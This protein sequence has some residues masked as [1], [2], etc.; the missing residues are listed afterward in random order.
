MTTHLKIR[1]G[2]T[3]LDTY[4]PMPEDLIEIDFDYIADFDYVLNR[5][6]DV[7]NGAAYQWDG[8]QTMRLIAMLATE[9]LKVHGQT[10]EFGQ[11]DI[12]AIRDRIEE[13]R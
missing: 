11:T 8:P 12:E 5:I 9:H 10:V 3:E 7:V 4:H 2:F 13:A 6:T 1:N